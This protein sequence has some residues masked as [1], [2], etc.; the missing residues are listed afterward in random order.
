MGP[1]ETPSRVMQASPNMF[2]TLQFSPD[3]FSMQSMG[4]A[5]APIY[6]QQRLFWEQP[7]QNQSNSPADQFNMPYQES[8]DAS[9]HS[10]S[11]IVPNYSP[12][13]SQD[14]NF[15]LPQQ[16][17]PAGPF[18]DATAFP[19][20]FQTSPRPPPPTV[21]NPTQFLSSPAR[22]FGGSD[23]PLNTSYKRPARDVPAYHHQI[24]ESRRERE[25]EKRRTKNAAKRADA[26]LIMSSVRRALSPSKTFRPS[27]KR[28]QTH[29]GVANLQLH[30]RSS[31]VSLND[32]ASASSAASA[33]SGR[34]GRSSPLKSI[35]QM[36]GSSIS[37]SRPSQKARRAVSLAIDENGV[38][39]TVLQELPESDTE[40]DMDEDSQSVISSA[41]EGDFNAIRSQNTSFRFDDDDTSLQVPR[42]TTKVSGRH[43]DTGR[44]TSGSR[45]ISLGSNDRR[46]VMPAGR[47]DAQ[48]ALKAIMEDRSR[49][50]SAAGGYSSSRQSDSSVQ[51]HSSPPMQQNQFGELSGS[52]TTITD[53]D[54]AT[55]STDQDSYGGLNATRCICN[56]ISLDG[57]PM[58]QW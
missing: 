41:D 32:S 23:V 30:R 9:F 29:S 31:R 35:R 54:L 4:P 8:F 15:D 19:M 45:T 18:L 38:A 28:S 7:G 22:R 26:E 10:S 50:V 5:T 46:T 13:A 24:E 56:S 53:P 2:P 43:S 36:S 57:S 33:E 17:S 21:E 11:T 1:P 40:M 20:P 39:K 14:S 12:V 27:L 49:S 51:F 47:G 55:P 48:K 34:N 16:P 52:P 37:K 25:S 44:S 3:L 6:P 58:I 42:H